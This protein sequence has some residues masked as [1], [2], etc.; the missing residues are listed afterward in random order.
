MRELTDVER[1]NAL[2]ER[3]GDAAKKP[4]EVYFTGGATAILLGWRSTTVD[5]DLKLEGDAEALLRTIPELKEGL[6]INVELACPSDF[7]PEV[8]GWRTRCLFI[9]RHGQLNFR[10]YDLYSQALA[11]IER[12]HLLDARD[13]AEMLARGLIEREHLRELFER[14]EPELYRYPAIDPPAFRRRVEGVVQPK[15][16]AG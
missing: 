5:V 4:G 1:L 6:R 9:V 8:P 13:V 15:P 11:K 16:R 2:M 10:H 12:N 7:I 3:L 14:I